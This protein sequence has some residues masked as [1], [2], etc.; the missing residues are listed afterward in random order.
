MHLYGAGM[1]SGDIQSTFAE[2]SLQVRVVQ[3]M[4]LSGHAIWTNDAG[5][6][7]NGNPSDPTFQELI[8]RWLQ[9]RVAH[10]KVPRCF[11]GW[12]WLWC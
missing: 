12:R 11:Q 7:A 10:K 2:L 6:Y 1:W 3:G 5:G 9:V 8:V 4:A